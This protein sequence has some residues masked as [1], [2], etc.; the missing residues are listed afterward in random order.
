MR[1]GSTAPG[2]P[3]IALTDDGPSS[4]GFGSKADAALAAGWKADMS[5]VV[6][7]A[8]DPPDPL[9]KPYLGKSTH[10]VAPLLRG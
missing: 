1:F 5:L 8:Q 2:R 7:N 4:G 10:E 6:N 3:P 9:T